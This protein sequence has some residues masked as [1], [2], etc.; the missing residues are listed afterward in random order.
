MASLAKHPFLMRYFI[1]YNVGLFSTTKIPIY[2]PTYIPSTIPKPD[3]LPLLLSSKAV[4]L[5]H[6]GSVIYDHDLSHLFQLQL[7][8]E[9]LSKLY[10]LSINLPSPTALSESDVVSF[11]LAHHIPLHP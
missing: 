2:H 9:Y 11:Q 7:Q 3:L 8:L 1:H 6:H 10:L 5:S 4:L